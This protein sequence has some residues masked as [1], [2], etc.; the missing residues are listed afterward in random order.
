MYKDLYISG[1]FLDV[2]KEKYRY[3][4]VTDTRDVVFQTNPSE[5]LSKH[6]INKQLIASS[7]GL[8]YKDEPWGN[9]NLYQTFGPFLHDKLKDSLIHNVGT[10][11]GQFDYVKDLLLMIFQMSLNRPISVVD[12]AVYNFLINQKPYNDLLHYTTNRDSWA[13]QLG[14]TRSAIESGAGDIG[15]MAKQDPTV[16]K[17]YLEAYQ[18]TQPIIDAHIVK[19]EQGVPYCIVHQYDRIDSL[20][21]LVLQEYDDKSNGDN[22]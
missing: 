7:E 19:T 18:D 20:K 9:Q 16:L 2:L 13:I 10:I 5:Y 3:V 11:A 21:P 15:I 6:C 8:A 22:K 12:Q 4:I 17:K 1:N 14:T